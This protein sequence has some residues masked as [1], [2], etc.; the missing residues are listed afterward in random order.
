MRSV[1]LD[2]DAAAELI[3]QMAGHELA[4]LERLQV[5]AAFYLAGGRVMRLVQFGA[6][7]RLTRNRPGP[8]PS[9]PL[10]PLEQVRLLAAGLSARPGA[11]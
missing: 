4:G 10:S 6:F 7:L 9:S 5:S 8:A 11:S 1:P 3:A 2:L